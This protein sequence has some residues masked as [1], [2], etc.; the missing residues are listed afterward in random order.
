MTVEKNLKE[1]AKGFIEE[2]N[3]PVTRFA[4]DVDLSSIT[5]HKWL[6]GDIEIGEKSRNRIDAFMKSFNR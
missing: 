2:L 5:I 3:L 6:K 1:R 4:K